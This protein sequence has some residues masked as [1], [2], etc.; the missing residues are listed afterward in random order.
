MHSILHITVDEDERRIGSPVLFMHDEAE[1]SSRP[2]RGRGG[3]REQETN[4]RDRGNH[5]HDAS[6]KQ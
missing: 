6:N 2:G 5:F 1:R 3:M 4:Q